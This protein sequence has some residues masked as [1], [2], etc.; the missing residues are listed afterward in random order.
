MKK[1]RLYGCPKEMVETYKMISSTIKVDISSIVD[2]DLNKTVNEIFAC[3]SQFEENKNCEEMFMIFQGFSPDEML[4]YLNVLKEHDVPY[5]GI[6]IIETEHNKNWKL[7]DLFN[8]VRLEHE[9]FKKSEILKQVLMATSN[10][11]LDKLS[12]DDK[13][14]FKELLMKGYMMLQNPSREQEI[15]DT[16]TREI[17][18]YLKKM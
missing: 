12:D 5:G 14:K 2:S 4:N 16:C 13:T 10:V 3:D 11:N 18:N 1:I 8:E 15:I 7:A 17:M 6:K 9:I